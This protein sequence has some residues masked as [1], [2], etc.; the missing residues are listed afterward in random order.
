[1][2]CQ[3]CLGLEKEGTVSQR[4]PWTLR[5]VEN[6]QRSFHI[7]G[8]FHTRPLKRQHWWQ[9][10]LP[11]TD[12]LLAPCGAKGAVHRMDRSRHDMLELGRV[13]SAPWELTHQYLS[14]LCKVTHGLLA[15]RGASSVDLA[16]E[17][18]RRRRA[19]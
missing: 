15:T 11:L 13:A 7:A 9:E 8:F 17:A 2:T 3:A 16:T 18:S 1:M 6:F 14:S 4:M 10:I 5:S 19:Q 12:R